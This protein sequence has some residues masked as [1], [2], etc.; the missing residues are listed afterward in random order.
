MVLPLLLLLIEMY[1]CEIDSVGAAFIPYSEGGCRMGKEF[2]LGE[3]VERIDWDGEDHVYTWQHTK[4]LLEIFTRYGV[5][6]KRSS[7]SEDYFKFPTSNPVNTT[8]W[9]SPAKNTTPNAKVPEN[10]DTVKITILDP[11]CGNTAINFSKDASSLIS[12]VPGE[13]LKVGVNSERII[14]KV[15]SYDDSPYAIVPQ[16]RNAGCLRISNR[17]LFRLLDSYDYP[18]P[19]TMP[20]RV[21]EDDSGWYCS[22]SE[23]EIYK[24]VKRSK[25]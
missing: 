12:L 14:I 22:K 9:I 1:K 20:M 5:L 15:A 7:D 2:T 25:R 6:E 10:C 23:A 21:L 4:T 11:S 18:I 3:I 19:C 16:I 24:P 17:E 13:C 8:K